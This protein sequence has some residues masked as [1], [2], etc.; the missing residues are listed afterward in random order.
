MASGPVPNAPAGAPPTAATGAPGG[1][2]GAPDPTVREL[3][4]ISRTL[5]LVLAVVAGLLF[6]LLLS[7]AFLDVLLGHGAGGLL[8]AGYCLVSAVVNFVVWRELPALQQLAASGQYARLREQ[9]LVWAVLGI[10]FFFVVGVLLLFAW[11]KVE[12]RTERPAG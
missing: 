1:S 6:L 10:V 8:A 7:L 2:P 11:V 5:A 4:S 12:G 9:L 3:L